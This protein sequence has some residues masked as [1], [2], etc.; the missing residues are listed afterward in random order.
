MSN[1]WVLSETGSRCASFKK[2][3]KAFFSTQI[4]FSSGFNCGAVETAVKKVDI[5]SKIRPVSRACFPL[6]LRWS[7]RFPPDLARQP[8][9]FWSMGREV[10]A[11]M[12]SEGSA[13]RQK[14]F[15]QL[16]TR[17]MMPA[18]IRVGLSDWVVNP[19]HP[20]WFLS[21]SNTFSQSPR[22]R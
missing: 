13:R 8:M 16:K 20:H 9:T 1:S 21:S 5:F 15:H 6:M 19:P 7:S 4:H 22:S 12:C 2:C 14:M 10:I 11:S 17:A 3:S 18:M